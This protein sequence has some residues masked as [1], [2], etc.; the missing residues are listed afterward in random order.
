[1]WVIARRSLREFSALHADAKNELEAWYRVAKKARWQRFN[2]VRRVY[3]KR[4]DR[5]GEC[6]IFDIRGNK[7]RLVTVVSRDWTIVLVCVFL[8]HAEYDRDPWQNTCQ[9]HPGH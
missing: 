8:T 5:V 4:V 7:Y 1:M 6:Y 2:D 9:C 3:G